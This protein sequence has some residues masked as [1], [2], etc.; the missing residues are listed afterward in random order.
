MP[1]VLGE[2]GGATAFDAMAPEEVAKAFDRHITFMKVKNAVTARLVGLAF[3]RV[4]LVHHAHEAHTLHS[5][6]KALRRILEA[7]ASWTLRIE[8]F[9]SRCQT[10]YFLKFTSIFQRQ[11]YIEKSNF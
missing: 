10:F 7:Y 8:R 2:G 5:S 11:F 1:A 4:S 6:R 9:C 3:K